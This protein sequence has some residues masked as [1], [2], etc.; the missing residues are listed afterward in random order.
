MR[1]TKPIYLGE[2]IQIEI[3]LMDD[4]SDNASKK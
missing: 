2:E 4:S 3:K 1:F